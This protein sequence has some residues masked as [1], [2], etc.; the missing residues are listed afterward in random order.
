MT[1]GMIKEAR[2]ATRLDIYDV[3]VRTWNSDET[4]GLE[5]GKGSKEDLD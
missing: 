1:I 5:K 3:L 2:A 4:A